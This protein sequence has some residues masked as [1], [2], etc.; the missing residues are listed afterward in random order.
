MPQHQVLCKKVTL[1]P[2]TVELRR[3][4]LTFVSTRCLMPPATCH[5]SQASCPMPHR[6]PHTKSQPSKAANPGN[7]V[8]GGLL[9]A[10]STARCASLACFLL[11][12]PTRSLQ[13]RSL[14]ADS[15]NRLPDGCALSGSN[16]CLVHDKKTDSRLTVCIFLVHLQGFEP[17]T[18]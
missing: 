16:P 1:N 18:P 11:Q 10:A 6:R 7:F 9:L 4:W 12:L 2:Q 13:N 17:W 5:R 3:R 14:L 8:G 15:Q